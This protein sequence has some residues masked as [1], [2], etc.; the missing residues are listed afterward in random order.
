[1]ETRANLVNHSPSQG[2]ALWLVACVL[3]VPVLVRAQWLGADYATY[4]A[5][6][7]SFVAASYLNQATILHGVRAAARQSAPLQPKANDRH[8]YPGGD[9]SQ[10]AKELAA[11][12]PNHVRTQLEQVFLKAPIVWREY[13]GKLGVP[14]EDLSGSTAMYIAGNWMALTGKEASDAQFLSL[15]RR[16]QENLDGSQTLKSVSDSDKRRMHDQLMMVGVMMALAQQSL[17]LRPDEVAQSNIQRFA[18]QN[19]KQMLGVA[20][21]QLLEATGSLGLQ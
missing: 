11:R 9:A 7:S 3:F 4:G 1:M 6:Y 15:V 12:F 14:S 20:D 21:S 8:V 10:T 19:L 18:T 2:W 17:R 16:L 5:Q 13:A